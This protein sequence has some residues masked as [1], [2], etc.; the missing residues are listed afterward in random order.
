MARLDDWEGRL[1]AYLATPGRD[2]FSWGSNDCALFCAG[3]VEAVTGV[4]PFP[5]VVGTY[6]DALGAAEVLR[7]LGGTLFR[8][9]NSAF[10]RKPIGFAQRGDLVFAQKAVGICM[11]ARGVFLQADVPGFAMLPRAEFTHAWEV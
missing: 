9:I 4:H 5:Q 11:G 3:G 6:H 7:E 8:T 10:P 2:V 1:T